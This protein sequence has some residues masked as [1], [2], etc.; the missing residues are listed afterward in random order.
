MGGGLSRVVLM[1]FG[2]GYGHFNFFS[3]ELPTR[4]LPSWASGVGCFPMG[5]LVYGTW[6]RV[7]R[8]APWS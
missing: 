6:S 8:D 7:T 2:L 5:M 3:G 1:R 4:S